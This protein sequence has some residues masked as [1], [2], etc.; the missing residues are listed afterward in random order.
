MIKTY[1][2]KYISTGQDKYILFFTEDDKSQQN[3]RCS[4]KTAKAPVDI[5]VENSVANKSLL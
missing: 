3:Q 2:I 1:K 4:M 5:I